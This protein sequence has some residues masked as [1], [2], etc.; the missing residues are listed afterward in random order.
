VFL[1][2]PSTVILSDQ[3]VKQKTFFVM[4]V[5]T[6]IAAPQTPLKAP[7]PLK[8]NVASQRPVFGYLVVKAVK[9]YQP[10]PLKMKTNSNRIL[11]IGK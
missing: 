4:S 7:T 5:S 6:Q 9:E 1:I 3:S 11:S 10:L 8:V 2:H